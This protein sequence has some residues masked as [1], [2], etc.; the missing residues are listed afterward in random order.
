[1]VQLEEKHILFIKDMVCSGFTIEEIYT[2]F[3]NKYPDFE[4]GLSFF[5]D[6]E[7]VLINIVY[8]EEIDVD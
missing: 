4:K 7:K 8:E 6:P 1:M 5:D 2:S 3:I